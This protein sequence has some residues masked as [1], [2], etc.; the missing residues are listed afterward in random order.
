MKTIFSRNTFKK[1]IFLFLLMF[2][3]ILQ[4]IAQD[5]IIK[6]SGDTIYCKI[7]NVDT[8]KIT[9]EI[10]K[11]ERVINTY[12]SKEEI[13]EYKIAKINEEL[14]LFELL[15]LGPDIII[16]KTGDTIYCK[17]TNVDSTKIAFDIRKN[18]KLINTYL[19]KEEIKEYIIAKSYEESLQEM[20]NLELDSAIR[21][22]NKLIRQGVT[23]TILGPIATIGGLVLIGISQNNDDLKGL[24]LV[25]GILSTSLGILSTITG[26]VTIPIGI[27]D[28]HNFKNELRKRQNGSLFISPTQNGLG[29]VYNF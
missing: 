22:C 20:S 10:V 9:F 27:S 1:S 21:D 25:S 4:I 29:L 12:L 3:N 7:T 24:H 28:K 26:I 11:N 17:I 2:L 5:M 23:L 16:K 19:S 18:K 6:K 13:K 8:S 14:S 15:Q